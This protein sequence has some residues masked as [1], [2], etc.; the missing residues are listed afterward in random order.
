MAEL[1]A[2]EDLSG[3]AG[4]EQQHRHKAY[5]RQKEQ[6]AQR[7]EDER[8]EREYPACVRLAILLTEPLAFVRLHNADD[9]Q[10]KSSRLEHKNQQQGQKAEHERNR[11]ACFFRLIFHY[12]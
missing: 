8:Q 12:G 7:G 3:L 2:Q 5:E 9:S 4:H 11:S 10:H 1:P 6:Q